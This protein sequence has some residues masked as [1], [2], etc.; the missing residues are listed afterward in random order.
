[1]HSSVLLPSPL[2]QLRASLSAG[3][4]VVSG[5]EMTTGLALPHLRNSID[6]SSPVLISRML[7]IQYSTACRL[8][9][10]VESVPPSGR[11]EPTPE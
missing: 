1:M 6:T 9:C 10:A 8:T 4:A 11:A 7:T 5:P 2:G 3:G